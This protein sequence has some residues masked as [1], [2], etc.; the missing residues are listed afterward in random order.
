MKTLKFPKVTYV[1]CCENGLYGLDYLIRHKCP[2]SSVVSISPADGKKYQ[3]S[4]YAD[5]RPICRREKIQLNHCSGYQVETKDIAGRPDI[6]IVNGW[7][8]LIKTEVISKHPL[9][10]LA[11]HAGHPPI[12]LGRAPLPWNLIK[13]FKDLE[14]YVFRMTSEADDGDIAALKTVEITPWDNVQTLYEKVMHAGAEMFF[15]V[16][17]SPNLKSRLEKSIRQNLKHK[18]LYPKRNPEDGAIDFC[19]DEI[20]IH[21]FVRAQSKPYPGAFAGLEGKE[22]I[23]WDAVPYDAFSFRGHLR[24]PGEILLGLPSGLVVMTG[25]APIWIREAECEGKKIAMGNWQA[26]RKFVGKVFNEQS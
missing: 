4:G 26:L 18:L 23:I 17:S 6:L 13:G 1:S 22:W 11:I 2:V 8:R 12:G 5:F 10:G 16:L 25:G 7:N 21:N 15:D 19:W 24:T 9:G 20:T 14:V 3:V